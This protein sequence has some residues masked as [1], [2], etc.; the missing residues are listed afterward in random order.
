MKVILS[1]EP[2]RYPLTGIGRYTYELALRLGQAPEIDQL[3]YFSGTRMLPEL[4]HPSSQSDGSYSLKRVIQQSSLA[5]EAYRLLMPL[6]KAKS[7]RPWKDHLYHGPNFFLPPFSGKKVATF[8]DLS[9]FSWAHCHPAQRVGFLQKELLK[10][11][12]HADALITDSEYVRREIAEHFS[13]PLERIHTVPLAS[14]DDFRPRKEPE[15]SATLAKHSLVMGGYALFVGT[16]EPR[17]NLQTLL[18]SYSRLPISLR[19]RWPL[20]LTGYRGWRNDEIHRQIETGEREGWARYLGFVSHDDLP[21]LYAGA[22]L[23]AFPSLYEGFGLP[24]LEAMK[25]GVPVVCSTSSSLPEVAGNAALTCEAL[26]VDALTN[27]LQQGLEDEIWRTE[28]IGNG[29][30]NAASFSWERCTQETIQ[31]YEQVLREG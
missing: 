10:T 22:R 16:I 3:H 18:S 31:V 12:K 4:P 6:L 7:L 29:L 21:L 13:W 11:L 19:K 15:L 24:V 23:F 8:H 17:K 2:V 28:A 1:V 30:Q 5:I 9:P 26:D 25:S 27:A 14:S 20:V